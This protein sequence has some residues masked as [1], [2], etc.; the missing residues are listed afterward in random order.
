MYRSTL[1]ALLCTFISATKCLSGEFYYTSE[2]DRLT[3]EETSQ[4]LYHEIDDIEGIFSLT[5]FEFAVMP[6]YFFELNY[7]NIEISIYSSQDD[8]GIPYE[9]DVSINEE[10]SEPTYFTDSRCVWNT[11]RDEVIDAR[12]FFERY[13]NVANFMLGVFDREDPNSGDEFDSIM[14]MSLA[15]TIPWVISVKK[16]YP[17]TSLACELNLE[18]GRKHY[19]EYNFL[20]SQF[21]SFL[22]DQDKYFAGVFATNN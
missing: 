8:S 10:T 1:I 18:G 4:L 7:L 2:I 19:I 22:G 20:D 11:R 17:L 16:Y 12:L 13:I 5:K 21:Q 14:T 3:K 9:W 15:Y 6:I